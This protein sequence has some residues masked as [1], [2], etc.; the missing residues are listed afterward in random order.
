VTFGERLFQEI[1]QGGGSEIDLRIR[2][3]REI[4]FLKGNCDCS[5]A[6]H[7]TELLHDGKLVPDVGIFED[8]AVTNGVDVDRHPLDVIARARSSEELPA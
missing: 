7:E 1:A 2:E 8:F 6:L 4:A 5:G 3:T